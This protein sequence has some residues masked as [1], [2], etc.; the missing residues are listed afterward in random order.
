[1]QK[2]DISHYS[3]SSDYAKLIELLKQGVII[4]GFRNID[5]ESLLICAGVMHYDPKYNYYSIIGCDCY[6]H[7]IIELCQQLDV[8]FFD[9]NK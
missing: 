5:Y 2:S 9:I 8:I 6:E 7:N 1:M 4:S 3:L